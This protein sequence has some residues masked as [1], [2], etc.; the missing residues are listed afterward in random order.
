[1]ES[2]GYSWWISTKLVQEGPMLITEIIIWLFII[3][4]VETF[5][6]KFQPFN[7]FILTYI[8]QI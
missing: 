8:V 4:T 2:Y 1:M 3:C 6:I 7:N 5:G